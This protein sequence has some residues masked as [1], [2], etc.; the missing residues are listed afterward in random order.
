[1]WGREFMRRQLKI[2]GDK[3]DT[4]CQLKNSKHAVRG[5][6]S[7]FVSASS[8][9]LSRRRPAAGGG[10]VCLVAATT[11]ARA[12][13]VTTVRARCG[14]GVLVR[15]AA[16]CLY[17]RQRERGTAAAQATCGATECGTAASCSYRQRRHGPLGPQRPGAPPTPA[18]LT[19]IFTEVEDGG[20]CRRFTL[21]AVRCTG[22]P[23]WDVD[24]GFLPRRRRPPSST[25]MTSSTQ[26]RPLP[27]T[28][29]HGERR[30][31]PRSTSG[32]G[33]GG[34]G[35]GLWIF[36][37]SKKR[38]LLSVG[39]NRYHKEDVFRIGQIVSVVSTDT[40]KKLLTDT[41]KGFCSSG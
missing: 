3:R 4:E 16:S 2:L 11:T 20:A 24:D 36:F 25:V 21:T 27:P 31:L 6:T 40:I 5:V 34:L 17:Q 35:S 15:A 32:S 8:L 1:V 13:S 10:R 7:S 33:P 29:L 12:M 22:T 19:R 38:F 30:P 37:I 26:R 9:S 28:S 39:S 18:R 41:T 14:G 23:P